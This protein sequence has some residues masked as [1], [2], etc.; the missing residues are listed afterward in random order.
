M[1]YPKFVIYNLANNSFYFRLY[2]S[3]GK[4]LL[5]GEPQDTRFD[6]INDIQ[7]LYIIVDRNIHYR[8]RQTKENYFFEIICDQRKVIGT[9][10]AFRTLPGTEHGMQEVKKNVIVAVVEDYSRN[11]RFFTK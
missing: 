8:V 4:V 11:I 10:E 1:H 5:T 7:Q 3:R 6:C 2:N 9:S